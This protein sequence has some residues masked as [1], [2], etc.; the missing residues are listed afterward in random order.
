MGVHICSGV[1]GYC[2]KWFLHNVR[3]N[4]AFTCNLISSVLSLVPRPPF[5]EVKYIVTLWASYCYGSPKAKLLK[6]LGGLQ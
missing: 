3:L 1:S 4:I 5:K 2:L 6:C